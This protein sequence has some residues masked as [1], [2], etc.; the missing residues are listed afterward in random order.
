MFREFLLSQFKR[1]HPTIIQDLYHRASLWFAA[2]GYENEAVTYALESGD[3]D[4]AAM[5]VEQHG[6]RLL[7]RGQMPRL[8]HW[9]KKLPTTVTERRP[10]L[11]ML[12]C[13]ALFHMNRPEEAAQA[14]HQAEEVIEFMGDSG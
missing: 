13:W 14:L 3:F 9:L 8:Y 7:N 11:P 6:M 10:Q 4:H 2:Q 1:R 5:L 12:R